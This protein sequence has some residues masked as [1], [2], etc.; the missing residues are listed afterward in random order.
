[1]PTSTAA[2]ASSRGFLSATG[3]PLAIIVGILAWAWTLS[4][5]PAADATLALS[6]PLGGVFGL[7]LQRSRFCFF[8]VTR[9]FIDHRDARGLLGIV[10]AL[11]IGTLGYHAI[12]GLLVPDPGVG[13]LP[14]DAHIGPVSWVLAFAALVF[15][16]GMSLSGS[17]IS[18]HLYRIGEGVLPPLIALGGVIVG[19]GLGFVTWNPLYV[20][21]I[22]T[23]PVIWLPEYTGY[24]CST[25][26]QLG[27][28]GVIAA[29]LIR[30]HRASEVGEDAD[31]FRERLLLR[32]WPG[33]I[34]GLA[35][36]MVAVVAYLR[37]A[38]LGVTAE[39]GSVARTLGERSG[40]IPARLQG[41]DGFS[42]CATVIKDTLLSSNGEFIAG[43]VFAS[44]AY[45]LASGDFRWRP[46]NVRVAMGHFSGGVLM[47]WGAMTA[48]GCTVGTFLS[49]IMAGALTRWV[50]HQSGRVPRSRSSCPRKPAQAAP[51]RW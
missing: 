1:M 38:P 29:F 11:A 44:L 32:R 42:G 33:H 22:Q 12:F 50:S 43:L 18:A 23:A 3:L 5:G 27:A 46:V 14:P 4:S 15:G 2:P 37:V 49:G 34:G 19:F 41:L 21:A 10:V 30:R 35:I 31:G 24:G 6:L 26:L 40:A 28:L 16:I 13:R 8:S 20:S 45:A 39:L 7:L 36:G 51:P 48:L 9:D 47:G 25:L 17:G